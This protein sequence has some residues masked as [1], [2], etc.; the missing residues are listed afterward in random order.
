MAI[1][2]GE[3]GKY[4]VVEPFSIVSCILFICIILIL[5]ILHPLKKFYLKNPLCP[6]DG[7]EANT[8]FSLGMDTTWEVLSSMLEC[9]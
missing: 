4:E 9:L 2:K 6:L 3:S 1:K 5:N 8:A 7:R